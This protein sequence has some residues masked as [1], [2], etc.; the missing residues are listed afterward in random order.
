MSSRAWR[1]GR[2]GKP[3]DPGSWAGLGDSRWGCRWLSSG[4]AWSRARVVR[5]HTQC[6]AR[7]Q[8]E[9]SSGCLSLAAL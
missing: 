1:A 4:W 6:S 7:R 5:P 3:Q 8:A 2:R 9:P